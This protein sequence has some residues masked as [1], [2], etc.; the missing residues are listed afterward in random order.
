MDKNYLDKLENSVENDLTKLG[1][2]I[3]TLEKNLKE[4][5]YKDEP[6][7]DPIIEAE[8]LLK[9]FRLYKLYCKFLELEEN[10]AVHYKIDDKKTTY[11]DL[12][13]DIKAIIR[14]CSVDNENYDEYTRQFRKI[15]REKQ[16]Q[17]S[18]EKKMENEL[19]SAEFAEAVYRYRMRLGW[20]Q[21][22]LAKEAGL[23][24]DVIWRIEHNVYTKVN[25]GHKRAIEK[26]SDMSFDYF[27]QCFSKF[28]P[29]IRIDEYKDS[30]LAK[31]L[32]NEKS[33]KM[34]FFRLKYL[35]FIYKLV[36]IEDTHPDKF[37]EIK[38]GVENYCNEK[39]I[40]DSVYKW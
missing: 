1:E 6:E 16:K 31:F 32:A 19:K 20:S 38:E 21:K 26:V 8:N 27:I 15:L 37:E 34:D 7:K 18:L 39:N 29:V 36:R 17:E 23:S 5:P 30:K 14:K 2:A 10:I 9:D 4:M 24:K 33:D 35:D 13:D 40:P 28:H 22:R 3:D 25:E 12:F 11:G